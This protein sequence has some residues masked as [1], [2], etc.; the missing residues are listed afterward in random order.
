MFCPKCGSEIAEGAAFAEA[1]PVG[2]GAGAAQA[3]ARRAQ[4]LPSAD[5]GTQR[6]ADSRRAAVVVVV[7]LVAGFATNWFARRRAAHEAE[8]PPRA[9]ADEAQGAADARRDANESAATPRRLPVL[10]ASR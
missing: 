7:V 1:A 4:V 9:S 3:G 2:P 10:P 6:T 5:A 8:V